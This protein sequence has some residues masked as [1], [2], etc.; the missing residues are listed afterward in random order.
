MK[1]Y[2]SLVLILLWQVHAAGPLERVSFK[3]ALPAKSPLTVVAYGNN[4]FVAG[5]YNSTM[6]YS[7]DGERWQLLAPRFTPLALIFANGRF[8]AP[9]AAGSISTSNDGLN[10]TQTYA[11]APLSFNR[12]AFGNGAFVAI[13]LSG[14]ITTSTNGLDW[15]AESFTDRLTDVAFGNGIFVAA[16]G[17]SNVLTSVN[18]FRWVQHA[19]PFAAQK[20]V[21]GDGK[22]LAA[23]GSSKLWSSSDGLNWT[24]FAA[25]YLTEL[26]FAGQ[27]WFARSQSTLVRSRD[28]VVWSSSDFPFTFSD[29]VYGQ[30]K[31]VAVGRSLSGAPLMMISSDG[32]SWSSIGTGVYS[33]FPQNGVNKVA[34]AE[35]RFWAAGNLSEENAMVSST[36]MLNSLNGL[37]WTPFFPGQ[38]DG[39]LLSLAADDGRIVA[40]GGWT[41]FFPGSSIVVR[42]ENQIWVSIAITLGLTNLTFGAGQF[43]AV[44]P[45]GTLASSSDG[46]FWMKLDS[47]TTNNL[48]SITYG[49]GQFVAVGERGTILRSTNGIDWSRVPVIFTGALKSITAGNG[50]FIAVGPSGLI[51]S[52]VD[53][54]NWTVT[55]LGTSATLNDAAYGNEL[56][57]VVGDAGTIGIS[58]NAVNWVSA[59]RTSSGSLKTVAFGDGKFVI[60]GDSTLVADLNQ[61]ILTGPELNPTGFELSISGAIGRAF[62]IQTTSNLGSDWQ[63]IGSVTNDHFTVRFRDNTP[64]AT[65]KFYRSVLAR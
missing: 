61:S 30:G 19:V 46:V 34:Y 26:F 33:R 31:Y 4:A 62:R 28:A 39:N 54:I 60:G 12:M 3:D 59:T 11:G 44:G 36:I 49:N 10:W 20:I 37:A 40:I 22:F 6:L 48:K 17:G 42:N 53:A 21:Y 13:N 51:A 9:A 63:D 2:A 7:N 58:T 24:S 55:H 27:Q 43:I 25:P 64:P 1:R 32:G 57:V 8:V 50:T 29:V 15:N 23:L 52:S 56:F 41:S 47:P 35:G 18:G 38:N 65:Q 5:G 45:S 16:T 14:W